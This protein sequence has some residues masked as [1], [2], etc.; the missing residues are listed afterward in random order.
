MTSQE[1]TLYLSS[2]TFLFPTLWSASLPHYFISLSISLPHNI[3]S[4]DISPSLYYLSL[5]LSRT[6]FSP[7]PSL[8]LFLSY[9][10]PTSNLYLRLS[11]SIFKS[12]FPFSSLWKSIHT[13]RSFALFLMIFCLPPFSPLPS[14]IISLS[15]FYSLWERR[16]KTYYFRTNKNKIRK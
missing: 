2:S 11:S 15:I 9:Y 6:I 12:P 14:K 16:Q 1:S 7:S 4:L 13:P 3:I 10:I 5:Y 8:S